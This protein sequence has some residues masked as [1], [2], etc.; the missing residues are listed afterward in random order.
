MV[1]TS[2][3]AASDPAPEPPPDAPADTPAPAEA[4]EGL[5]LV[6]G[7]DELRRRVDELGIDLAQRYRGKRPVFVSILKGAT[8]FLADLT[9]SCPIELEID[10][11]S[12]S[13]YGASNTSS[14]VVRIEKDLATNITG[15]HV[16]IVED[17]VD[18]GLTLNYLLRVLQA[19]DPES[20]AVCALLDKDVRRIVELPIEYRGFS[21]PDEFVIGYGLDY[22]QLYRNVDAIYAVE[23]VEALV[24]DPTRF[25]GGFFG[26]D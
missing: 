8:H 9:R 3:P 13:S 2:E 4:P 7:S 21:I 17:I 25:V 20:V 22:A 6:I 11:M 12:I 23:D 15:R 16:V 19:R 10:F 5:R 24:H 1:V 14:G 26:T 18:T